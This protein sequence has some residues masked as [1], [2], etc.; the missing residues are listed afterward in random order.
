M[1]KLPGIIKKLIS[2]R[3]FAHIGFCMAVVALFIFAINFYI[4]DMRSNEAQLGY[5]ACFY[6]LVCVYTGRWVSQ[7]WFLKNQFGLF[8]LAA[9][10]SCVILIIAGGLLVQAR[11]HLHN[12]SFTD[13]LLK[14]A[15]F[16]IISFVLGVF[17]RL[18]RAG[19]QTQLKDAKATAA[20]RQIELELLQSQLSPHFLFN[21]LNNIYGLSLTQQEKI[22]PLLLKLSDLLRYSVYTTNELFVPITEE[23]TYIN[24]YMDFEKIRLGDRLVLTTSIENITDPSIKIAPMLLVVF[25]E[26]A[27]KH[28][29]N[30]LDQKIRI[31]ISFKKSDNFILFSVNNSQGMNI[32]KRKGNKDQFGLGLTNTIKRLDLIYPGAYSLEQ[33]SDEKTYKVQLRLKVE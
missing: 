28:S 11:L 33:Q 30:T 6:F 17:I 3:A 16:F 26:N 5:V 13:F 19:F 8:F 12:K 1:E 29:R 31:D 27:F 15:P 2:A 22:P 10:F 24:N 23:L 18:V 21:T 32:E 9:L 20:Q 4:G 25:V 7:K 14:I